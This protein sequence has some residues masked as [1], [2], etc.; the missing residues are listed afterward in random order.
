M[1]TP[2]PPQSPHRSPSQ[3]QR[4][5][6]AFLSREA[7]A[8]G[9][10]PSRITLWGQSAGG[11]SIANH[12]VSPRAAGLFSAAII[13]SGSFADWSAQP[14]NISRTRLPQVAA[15]VGCAPGPALLSCLRAA[16]AS[17]VL[18][19]DANLTAGQLEWGPTIDGVEV[20][21][22][23]RVLA[24]RG[25]AAPVPVLLGFNADE[26]TIF[27]PV[28]PELNAS[29]YAS[30]V[31][32]VLG[33]ALAPGAVAAYPLSDYESPW[34]AVAAMLGDSQV[35]SQLPGA[36]A[37]PVAAMRA[38][39]LNHCPLFPVARPRADALPGQAERR[40]AVGTV[41]ACRCRAAPVRVRVPLHARPRGH[42]R[43]RRRWRA[44]AVLP[45]S[46]RHAC[47][48]GVLGLMAVPCTDGK[49]ADA[50]GIASLVWCHSVTGGFGSGL[51]Y[52]RLSMRHVHASPHPPSLVPTLYR[53]RSASELF[54]VFDFS[55]LLL[56]GGEPAAAASMIAYWANFAVSGNPN[57]PGLPQWPPYDAGAGGDD[58]VAQIGATAAGINV[59]VVRGLLA[60]QCAYWGSVVIP[61]AVIW[62]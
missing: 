50:E 1:P 30:A 56:G 11:A 20:L 21:D 26:G 28:D 16:N 19:A 14:Y 43:P 52:T 35:R 12:L 7:G 48:R 60:A 45:V 23:P 51:C 31:A 33:P 58:A 47:G 5:A 2:R 8:F 15:N 25:R 4:A 6:L 29:D 27:N 38:D 53:P 3:D 9:G 10:D 37:P 62:G 32:R 49:D 61:P 24:A 40:V 34:W 36:S 41:N 42:R 39:A 18:A 54:S 46:R 55:L 44:P 57:G 17:V 13:E 22:D 59:T